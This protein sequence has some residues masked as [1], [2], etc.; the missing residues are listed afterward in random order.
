[1]KYTK[2]QN[3]L[4]EL[5]HT[6]RLDCL[7]LLHS[8]DKTEGSRMIRNRKPMGDGTRLEGGRGVKSLARSTRVDSAKN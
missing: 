1:M 6:I 8:W 7:S 3:Q 2:C 5:H 4:D